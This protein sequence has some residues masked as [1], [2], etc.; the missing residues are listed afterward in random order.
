MKTKKRVEISPISS[1]FLAIPLSLYVAA[2]TVYI[3]PASFM[4]SMGFYA[5]HPV[6]FLLNWWPHFA[7]LA[8]LFCLCRNVFYA[9][10]GTALIFNSLSLANTA[11]IIGR[12]DPLVPADLSLA[13]EALMAAKEYRLEISP[14]LFSAAFGSI[15]LFL[16]LGLLVKTRRSGQ[17]GKIPVLAA[18]AGGSVT[19]DMEPGKTLFVPE[20]RSRGGFP[21]GRHSLSG[22]RHSFPGSRRGL[23]C[24]LAAGLLVLVLFLL[25]F[26]FVYQD[27]VF[28]ES[29]MFETSSYYHITTVFNELGFTYCFFV[30][31]NKYPVTK[32]EGYSA[33]EVE[34]WIGDYTSR[35]PAEVA[36]QG[37][38]GKEGSSVRPHVIMVMNEAFSDLS[39]SDMFDY[40]PEEDPLRNFKALA[41]GENALA[42]H[43]VVS[44]FGAGTA[45]TEFDVLTGMQTNLINDHETSAF[46]AVHRN[47]GAFPRI[48]AAEGYHTFFLHP[49]YSWFYN[50]ASVYQYFGV[51]DQIF[52]EAFSREDYKG[53]MVS[54]SACLARFLKAF[55]ERTAGTADPLFSYVVTIQNHQAYP[56]SKYAGIELAEVPLKTEISPAARE[57]LTVYLE[58][59]RDAD[60]MLKELT[61]QLSALDEPA[62]LVFF[63]DHRPSLGADYLVYREL[64]LDWIALDGPEYRIQANQTPFLIWANPSAA[65]ALDFSRRAAGLDLPENGVISSNFLSAVTAELMGLDTDPFFNY[66]NEMRRSLPVLLH[67]D[68]MNADGS[69][70]EHLTPAESGLAVKLKKWEYYKLK[71]EKVD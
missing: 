8:L 56:Y 62:I 68:Y 55:E 17:A 46:R 53:N 9:A 11:K 67:Q 65:E 51:S 59:V 35:E 21:R 36:L 1:A 12:D 6:L 42:G 52:S 60:R 27:Q 44:N 61:D 25:S 41:A 29:L 40:D 33:K 47:I 66:L 49:G 63:G 57:Q 2:V 71:T 64:A 38:Q 23:L 31:Y 15:L 20:R 7:L 45:N 48:L 22:K 13:R 43:I 37:G 24:R 39:D 14:L 30:N 19:A 28:Y 18:Q 16:A 50:R 70:T 10:A 4:T 26:T 3:E 54:D 69:F 5:E 58:G 34:S 32:P